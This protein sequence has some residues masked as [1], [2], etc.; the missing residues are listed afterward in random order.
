MRDSLCACFFVTSFLFRAQ[1]PLPH[2]VLRLQL[3]LQ[4]VLPRLNFARLVGTN[5]LYELLLRGGALLSRKANGESV[6]F[7]LAC[8]RSFDSDSTVKRCMT[9][10]E[11]L[12]WG[13]VFGFNLF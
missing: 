8:M 2:L 9:C 12:T 3:A 5:G 6:S 11:L 4:T 1:K 7:G 13:L 10:S